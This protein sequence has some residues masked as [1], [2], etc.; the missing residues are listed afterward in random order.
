MFVLSAAVVVAAVG[1]YAWRWF[2]PRETSIVGTIL[3][4]NV[5]QRTGV[6]QVVHPK[7]GDTID[8]LGEIP[9]QCEIRLRGRRASIS[10]LAA[11]DLVRA[12]GMLYR[13]G[14]VVATRLTVPPESARPAPTAGS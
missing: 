5:A 9:A 3:S 1:V 2:S 8:L 4:L 6:L 14:R 10:D 7:T 13:S 11:G 12:E